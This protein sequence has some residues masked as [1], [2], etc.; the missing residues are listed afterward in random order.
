MKEGE[1]SV[2]VSTLV[3]NI[4][5]IVKNLPFASKKSEEHFT[6]AIDSAK[7]TGSKGIM[8]VAYLG[9]GSL[10]I[11][12]KKTEQ[13]RECISEAITIFKEIGSEGYIKQAKE[14]LTS[15]G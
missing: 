1:G 14:A 13:A 8:G 4:H 9:L 10:H 12:K 11:N 5:F 7:E 6:K 15:L 3:K 2:S